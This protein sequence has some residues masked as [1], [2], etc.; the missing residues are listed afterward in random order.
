MRY[1]DASNTFVRSDD[2]GIS[3]VARVLVNSTIGIGGLLDPATGLGLI[4]HEEDWGQTFAKW[5]VPA[6]R[7]FV[8]PGLGPSTVRNTAARFFDGSTNPLR[9][10]YPV[11]HRNSL[12][13]LRALQDRANLLTVDGVVFGDKYIFYRDAYLQRREYLENDGEVI[14]PFADD[15]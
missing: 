5:G 14:D 7:Y 6:G 8:I 9:Y 13:A 3:D 10:L 2:D 11:R 1:A 15:F 4:D 12:Y